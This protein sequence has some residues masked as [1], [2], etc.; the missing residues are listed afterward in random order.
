MTLSAAASSFKPGPLRSAPIAFLNRDSEVDVKDEPKSAPVIVDS[1]SAR[2]PVGDEAGRDKGKGK[3]PQQPIGTAGTNS[4]TRPRVHFTTDVGPQ[5]N[6]PGCHYI[7]I[8]NVSPRDI[9][10][11]FKELYSEVS[12]VGKCSG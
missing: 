5:V 4:P 2:S 10:I 7:K 3:A 9:D 12:N 8:E 11:C 6:C 1:N